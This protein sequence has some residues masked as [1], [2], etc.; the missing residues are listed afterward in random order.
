M[1]ECVASRAAAWDCPISLHASLQGLRSNP[2]GEACLATIKIWEDARLGNHLCENE[3]RVL[4]NAAPGDARYGP[5]FEQRRIYNDSQE[6]R[7]LTPSQPR[8]LAD[9]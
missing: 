1:F 5:C 7:N 4:R 3:R 6:A 8:I 2:S 9:C